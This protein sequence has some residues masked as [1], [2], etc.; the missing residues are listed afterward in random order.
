VSENIMVWDFNLCLK[1]EF[2]IFY[3]NE[4]SNFM[5]GLT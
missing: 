1:Y 2:E 4:N 3:L 5:V